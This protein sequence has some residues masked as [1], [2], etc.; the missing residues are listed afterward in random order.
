MLDGARGIICA[1][2]LVGDLRKRG[3]VGWRLQHPVQFGLL[4][5]LR[6]RLKF[7]GTR[8]QMSGEEQSLL[9]ESCMLRL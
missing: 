4:A 1:K 6:S 2:R 7:R 9:D 3:F 5:F 8:L